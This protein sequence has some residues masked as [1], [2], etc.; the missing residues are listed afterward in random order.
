MGKLNSKH[1]QL[2]GRHGFA[3]V[4]LGILPSADDNE[5]LMTELFTCEDVVRLLE[6]DVQAA[7]RVAEQSDEVLAAC[8]KALPPLLLTK[9]AVSR[10]LSSLLAQE[11]TPEQAQSWASFLFWSSPVNIEWEEDSDED[12][13]IAQAIHRME[14]IG[15]V[16]DGELGPEEI[17]ELI[18]KLAHDQ[19]LRQS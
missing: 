15:D 14:E 13:T 9:Q 19:T 5:V 3:I 4:A 11:I 18:L 7:A 16:I 1:P 8:A 2:V 17:R 10:A 12:D 6:G